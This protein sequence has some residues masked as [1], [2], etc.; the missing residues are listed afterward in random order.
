MMARIR[1]T[2]RH[3]ETLEGL[4][5]KLEIGRAY[6]VDD[7]QIIVIDHGDGR[8][9]IKY[10]GKPGPQGIAGEPIPQ[11]QEQILALAEAS[12]RTS[13]N[14]LATVKRHGRDVKE[15]ARTSQE[16]ISAIDTAS[17]A[18]DEE[19][20]RTSQEDR[21]H[22]EDLLAERVDMLTSMTNSN[23][24]AISVLL[25]FLS[26]KF[27]RTDKILAT[28]SKSVAALYPDTWT[29]TPEGLTD[30]GVS[31]GEVIVSGGTAYKV[32]HSSFDGQTGTITVQLYDLYDYETAGDYVTGLDEG[33]VVEYDGSTWTITKLSGNNDE[34]VMTLVL[35]Q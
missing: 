2:V 16:S 20:A 22:V 26:D 33:D 13:K 6:F 18:R 29:D 11:L 8:G 21:E 25:Q 34:G 5:E 24:R 3:V 23:A 28:L 17:K 4:P 31:T 7:E 10:G 27:E 12:T 14:L 1:W 32:E 9:V 30:N 35:S 15:L 19:L